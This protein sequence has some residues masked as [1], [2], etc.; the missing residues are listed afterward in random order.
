MF[1]SDIQQHTLSVVFSKCDKHAYV[2]LILHNLH[3]F[4][5]TLLE[6]KYN[7]KCCAYMRVIINVTCF[8]NSSRNLQCAVTNYNLINTSILIIY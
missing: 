8:L 2:G 3:Y 5:F 4:L 6:D 1:P 7:R